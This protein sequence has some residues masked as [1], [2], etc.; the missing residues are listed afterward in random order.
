[1]AGKK[2]RNRGKQP[3]INLFTSVDDD[4]FDELVE[5]ETQQI[6]HVVIWE[7]TLA[8]ALAGTQTGLDTQTVLN[9]ASD[10]DSQTVFDIDL[11]LSEGVYFELYDASAYTALDAAPVQGDE[12]V[13]RQLLTLVSQGIQLDE[14]AVDEEDNLVL[15]LSGRQEPQLYLTVGGWLIEEWDELPG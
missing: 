10:P 11:Y 1:M 3:D 15:I 6:V 7:E 4:I 13:A 8:D 5:L 9:T 14:I 2:A 12:E